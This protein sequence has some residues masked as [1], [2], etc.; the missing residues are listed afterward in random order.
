[1]RDPAIAARL[2]NQPVQGGGKTYTGTI[3]VVR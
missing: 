2:G 3:A 1:M